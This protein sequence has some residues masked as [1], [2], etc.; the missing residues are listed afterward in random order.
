ME[1]AP[2]TPRCERWEEAER[3]GPAILFLFSNPASVA[4]G[5]VPGADVRIV[6]KRMGMNL[7]LNMSPLATSGW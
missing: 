2:D 1:G 7:N 6:S 5:H 3:R 4:R